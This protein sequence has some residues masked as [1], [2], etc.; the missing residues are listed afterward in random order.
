MAF[1]RKIVQKGVNSI[2][3]HRSVEVLITAGDD[4]PIGT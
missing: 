2:D 4:D 3:F 1:D